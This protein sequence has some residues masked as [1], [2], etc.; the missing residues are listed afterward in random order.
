MRARS[1]SREKKGRVEHMATCDVA[2]L[3]GHGSHQCAPR[4]WRGLPKI[5]GDYDLDATIL[6]RHNKDLP[7]RLAM[8]TR[9]MTAP[10]TA[11]YNPRTAYH[12]YSGYR[13]DE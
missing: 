5:S 4:E 7:H 6:H 1:E 12:G 11:G 9:G 13:G 3:G 10:I 2:N 8:Y